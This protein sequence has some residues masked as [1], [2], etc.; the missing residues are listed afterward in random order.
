MK[1]VEPRVFLIGE[2]R[3]VEDGLRAYLEHLGVENW[4]TDAPS[5]AERLCEVFGRLCY[6]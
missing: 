2:T 6:R 1:L 3:V 5:D 4:E